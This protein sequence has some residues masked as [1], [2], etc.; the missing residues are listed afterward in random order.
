M[1][2]FETISKV[3]LKL[4]SRINLGRRGVR[5]ELW[6][7]DTA[8]KLPHSPERAKQ[9][10]SSGWFLSQARLC[11]SQLQQNLFF[12]T[13]S[14][15]RLPTRSICLLALSTLSAICRSLFPLKRS[16]LAITQSEIQ[17]LISPISY[18][19]SYPP[20]PL[21]K[22]QKIA[23]E[24]YEKCFPLISYEQLKMFLDLIIMKLGWEP[25][26]YT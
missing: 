10:I 8:H 20:Y 23:R 6:T 15:T 16:K 26:K 2:K 19:N 13:R 22:M 1:S 18:P 12:P 25:T 5:A 24:K 3:S 9:N 7:L 11:H 17:A 14:S 21:V 4:P